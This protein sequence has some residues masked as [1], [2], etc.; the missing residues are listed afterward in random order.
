MAAVEASFEFLQW[1]PL[2]EKQKP[3]EV[4]LPLASF[5]EN[6]RDK[7]PRSNLVFER[8]P[9]R[10]HDV[11]GRQDAFGLDTH[12]FQFVRQPTAVRDLKDRAAVGEQYVPEMEAFLRRYL[13][14]GGEGGEARTFCFDLRLRESV[15][16]EE[17]SKRTVNLE[18]GFDPLLPAT[19]P[20]IDQTMHGANLRVR[21]HMGDEAD[22]LLRGRVRVINIW[23]PLA[24]VRSWPLGLCDSRTVKQDDLVTCDIVRRRYVG[25]TYFAKYNPD[26]RWYYLSD[27]E[28]DDVILV[29]V[30][31]SDPEVP[32]KRCLHA[33]FQPDDG[34][35]SQQQALRESIELRV[36]VFTES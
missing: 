29:K 36:L 16:A 5:G 33:S 13:G 11:R 18:D 8:R 27:M 7:I 23:R 24:R 26:Q 10:V 30:Y 21:R 4:F 28:F 19:H 32:A 17:F 34:T 3:Y 25:E 22:E 2:Y 35:G 6:N 12:G 1:Q 9:V 15:D 31:D 20:H 14:M